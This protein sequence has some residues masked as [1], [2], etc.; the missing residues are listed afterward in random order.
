MLNYNK[1]PVHYMLSGMQRYVEHG[2][3]PG[4]FLLAVL[5][6]DLRAAV[7]CADSNNI[8]ALTDWVVFCYSELPA[9]IWGSPERVKEHIRACASERVKRA[10]AQ[11]ESDET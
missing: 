2:I 4:D 6:N 3:V 9:N 11:G 1:V 8:E 10:K 5:R 7:N